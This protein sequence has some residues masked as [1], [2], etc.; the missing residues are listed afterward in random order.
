MGRVDGGLQGTRRD[1]DAPPAVR[2]M[3]GKMGLG[4]TSSPVDGV[5]IGA[6]NIFVLSGIVARMGVGSEKRTFCRVVCMQWG[7]DGDPRLQQ[8]LGVAPPPQHPALPGAGQCSS[9]PLQPPPPLG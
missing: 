5:C 9:L 8:H 6:E 4:D 1:G 3:E 7:R 2:G